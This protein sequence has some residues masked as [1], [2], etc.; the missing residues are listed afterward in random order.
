M[1]DDP[2]HVV[3][4]GTFT[5]VQ[6]HTSDASP[7]GIPTWGGRAGFYGITGTPTAVFDGSL[8][9]VGDGSAQGAYSAYLGDYNQR[10]AAPTDVTL[11]ATGVPGSAE[12]SFNIYTRVCLEEGGT[13][14]TMRIYMAQVL[15]RYGCSYCRYTFMQAAT[16]QDVTLQPGQCYVVIRVF[17]L[18]D[19]S[20]NNQANVKVV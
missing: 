9:E 4:D 19:T 2:N 11:T 6:I 20:W 16:I 15:D 18:N 13:A 7:Y 5:L 10:R 1:L 8:W 3:A 14:K 12:H 17:A